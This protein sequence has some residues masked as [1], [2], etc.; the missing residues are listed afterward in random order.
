MP[1]A[2]GVIV[3]AAAFWQV[4][5][6]GTHLHDDTFIS[7][8][9]ARSLAAGAGLTFNPGERVEGYTNF[10]WTVLLA[11]ALR[12]GL[13]AVHLAGVLSSL[14]LLLLVV[15]VARFGGSR[16]PHPWWALPAPLLLA[17]H[18]LARAESVGGLESALFALLVWWGFEAAVTPT[19][20]QGRVGAAFGLAMLVRP[21]AAG[22]FA[23]VLALQARRGAPALVREA[24]VFLG[25]VLPLFAFRFAYYGDLVPNT[26]HAK[27]AWSTQQALRG[28]RYAWDS[29][30]RILSW[31]V[32]GLALAG[33][34]RDWRM[35]AAGLALAHI[36]FVIA[37]GGDFA[38]TGRFLL[39]ALPLVLLLVQSALWRVRAALGG[40]RVWHDGF[41]ALLLGL[42]ALQIQRAGQAVLD[43]RRW[44]TMYPYDLAARRLLG[45]TLRAEF[46]ATTRVAVGSIGAIGYYAGLPIL[47]TFGLT[48][49]E[50]GRMPVPWMGQASAGHE[51]GDAEV[52]FRR[53]PEL[54]VFDR[55]F[56]APR[57]LTWEEFVGRARS[58]T[59]QLLVQDPRLR[60]RYRLRSFP[61]G[62][63]V[64]QVLERI[65]P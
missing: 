29:G 35:V 18:P 33:C 36:S 1:V 34:G 2:L 9:Y 58:P 28:A 5:H 3:G 4:R 48:D 49:A 62:E 40:N 26:F 63:R 12:L 19:G 8:R 41:A 17:L 30:G 61:T 6:L 44:E 56:I 15:R 22:L 16:A 11:A 21:E 31:P 25:L 51:K 45:E 54:I 7:L 53:A 39:P 52:V 50:I 24:A 20:R 13:D 32:L 10:L 38:P 27:V 65:A 55:G 43:G 37:V 59:E 46:T 57:V 47:D 23:V 14:C 42:A 60:Q 64:L